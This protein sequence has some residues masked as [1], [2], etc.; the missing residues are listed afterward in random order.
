[1]PIRAKALP[2]RTMLI[3]DFSYP[4]PDD[5]IARYPLTERDASKLLIRTADGGISEDTFRNI[6][7]HLPEGSLVVMN[8][9]RVIRAR[10]HFRKAT[11]ALIEVFC[12][13]PHEPRDYALSLG[14]QGG[15][16]WICL[17]GN[18]K[19]WKDE[20]LER[21]I[22]SGTK[23]ITLRAER[24]GTHG[25]DQIVRFS[26]DDDELS[27]AELLEA[28]GELPIPP[29]LE[30]A[31]EESDLTTYQTVYSKIEGSVAAPTAGL[32]FTDRV[33]ADLDRHGIE[34]AELTLH[35]G[36]GTFKPVKTERVEDHTMHAERISVS[37][38][39]VEQ[40]LAHQCR[41]TAVGTT[42]VRTL[43]SLYYLG[44]H[45]LANPDADP[46]ALSVSQWEA[47][48]KPAECSLLP[49]T[50]TTLNALLDYMERHGLDALQASTQILIQPGFRY[51]LVERMV[52]NFH[53]P[54]STLL[55]LVSA[56]IGN[57]WRAVYD[58]AL[59]HSFR[60]LSYGDACLLERSL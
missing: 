45:V 14:A 31:T 47:Y 54:R 6:A 5:R 50:P 48:G 51:R 9:T 58:Y 37:R 52:T 11:G 15:C 34:C 7:G 60:F 59:A 55:L 53:Q 25:S 16:T 28:T 44:L 8:N 33:L 49:S 46:A 24:I 17:V 19:K 43:E 30:R 35:V 42:S 20:V 39:V 23:A 3:Q 36:A 13:E 18:L 40:L 27:F 41:C 26:W 1:M 4:L 57:D 10:L 32:H 12:L 21:R 38:S 29:Y 56:F 2:L 22:D